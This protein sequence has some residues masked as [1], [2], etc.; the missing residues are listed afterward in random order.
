MATSS[1]VIVEG[2]HIIDNLELINTHIDDILRSVIDPHLKKYLRSYTQQNLKEYPG[3]VRYPIRWTS[4]KQRRAFF[5]TDGFGRGI[6]SGRTGEFRRG[7]DVTVNRY[8]GEA[9]IV[10]RSD[11]AVFIVGK[12]QQGFHADTGWLRLADHEDKVLDGANPVISKALDSEIRRFLF[13]RGIM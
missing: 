4:E 10:N 5:A 1:I 13:S 11:A 7:W 9:A 2:K 8:Q 6:G 3:S 12:W